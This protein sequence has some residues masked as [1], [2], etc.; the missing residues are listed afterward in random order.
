MPFN[1][2]LDLFG[3][4][5]KFIEFRKINEWVK[6]ILSLTC[7]F[8]LSGTFTTGTA[9]IAHRSTP[10]AIGEGLVMASVMATIIWRR[11]PLTKGLI[12]ALPEEEAGKEIN[13]NQQIITK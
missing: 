7:S 9:M 5:E 3:A 10:E 8:W 1:L 13:T 2:Q 4:I 6:L 12:L 11:S